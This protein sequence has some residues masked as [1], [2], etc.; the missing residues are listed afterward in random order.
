MYWN[1]YLLLNYLN[2]WHLRLAGYKFASMYKELDLINWN[3]KSTYDYFRS[4]EDPFFNICSYLDVTDLQRYSREKNYSFNLC[5]LYYSL[6]VANEM[7][8]FRMR[9]LDDKVIVYDRINCGSPVL[10]EDETFSFCYFVL[11]DSLEAFVRDGKERIAQQLESKELDPKTGE[12]NMIHYSVIPWT[13]FS[14][15]KHA[16]KFIEGDSIPKIVFGKYFE[17]SGRLKMPISV[18]VNHALMDGFH[19]GKYL[20]KLQEAIALPSSGTK[21]V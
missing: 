14:S 5:I 20:N 11:H 3:R 4:F 21:I 16:K 17:E 1:L 18:A 10:H 6:K 7:E 8:E 12:L 9:L 15:F 13:S 19:L 2:G